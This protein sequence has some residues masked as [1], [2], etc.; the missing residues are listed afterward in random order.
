MTTESKQFSIFFF[1][2]KCWLNQQIAFKYYHV[3]ISYGVV[4]NYTDLHKNV[5]VCELVELLLYIIDKLYIYW[6]HL[7]NF[8]TSAI[9]THTKLFVIWEYYKG[10]IIC[11]CCFCDYMKKCTIIHWLSMGFAWKTGNNVHCQSHVQ[12]TNALF[13]T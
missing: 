11:K 13:A 3:A 4:L 1:P 2:L 6:S 7:T 8:Y 9:S 12:L 5:E 10:S